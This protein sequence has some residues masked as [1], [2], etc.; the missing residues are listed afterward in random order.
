MN[1]IYLY[2]VNKH[3]SSWPLL[4]LQMRKS[5][6]ILKTQILRFQVLSFDVILP[7]SYKNGED[8]TTRFTQSDRDL[9][10]LTKAFW[11]TL[12]VPELILFC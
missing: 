3:I 6:D 1:G 11:V 7:V 5:N 4:G 2:F 9:N 12:T 10:C 8:I